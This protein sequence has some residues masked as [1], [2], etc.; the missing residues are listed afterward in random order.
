[1]ARLDDAP[2]CQQ[3]HG[4][5]HSRHRGSTYLS[6]RQICSI[7]RK[8]LTWGRANYKH[9]PWRSEAD[10]WLSFIAE[11][12]LQRTRASQV[13]S[14]FE[15]IRDRLP[16]ARSLV[17]GGRPVVDELT[18][19]LGLRRRGQLLLRAAEVIADRGGSPPE[20]L[21]ELRRLPG[22]GIYTSAAWL[23]LYRGKRAVIIDANVA[24]WLSRMTGGP[25]HRDPRGVRWVSELAERLTPQR[26][27]REYNY[28]V[29]DFTMAICSPR[30]PAC[31]SCHL[32]A[33]CAY[34]VRGGGAVTGGS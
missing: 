23:S 4:A 6:D 20:T 14:V 3:H 25:Y 16:T 10:P 28:A 21:E 9:Y 27:F 26:A 8:L 31:G 29:L 5:A 33:V 7:R 32:R 17:A 22:V 2:G 1:M 30:N 19:K 13:A 24:R 18:S 34:G 11:C 12:L 15:R